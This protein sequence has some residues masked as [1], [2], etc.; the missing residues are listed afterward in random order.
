MANFWQKIYENG[1]LFGSID[2][3]L[4]NGNFLAIFNIILIL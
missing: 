3:A 2:F 4:E 1:K